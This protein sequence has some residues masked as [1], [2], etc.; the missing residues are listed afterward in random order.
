MKFNSYGCTIA[1]NIDIHSVYTFDNYKL[2]L[3]QHCLECYN[4]L[5]EVTGIHQVWPLD[6][7]HYCWNGN[8][9]AVKGNDMILERGDDGFQRKKAWSDYTRQDSCY[10]IRQYFQEKHKYSCDVNELVPYPVR[11]HADCF[12]AINSN[13]T[14]SDITTEIQLF[15]N[16]KCS[17][18]N[19]GHYYD[20]I[21]DYNNGYVYNTSW[22]N[23]M[24]SMIIICIEEWLFCY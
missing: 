5:I 24:M 8:H 15:L 23:I 14:R 2:Y 3:E 9:V 16:D 21:I 17:L 20:P 12:V 1:S 22:L 13:V 4:R 18:C 6:T 10:Y 7:T 19:G 11:S